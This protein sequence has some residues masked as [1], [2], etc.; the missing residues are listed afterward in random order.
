[1]AEMQSTALLRVDRICAIE[2]KIQ[3]DGGLGKDDALWLVHQLKLKTAEC[4]GVDVEVR[5]IVKRINRILDNCKGL[6][7]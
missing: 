6:V 7:E 1:M 4:V 2:K 5:T 3:A